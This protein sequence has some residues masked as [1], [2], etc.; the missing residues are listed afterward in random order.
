MDLLVVCPY[1]AGSASPVK[2]T[3]RIPDI[4]YKLDSNGTSKRLTDGTHG[5]DTF[6]FSKVMRIVSPH[7]GNDPTVVWDFGPLFKSMGSISTSKQLNHD[8]LI[9]IEPVSGG[10]VKHELSLKFDNLVDHSRCQQGIRH[11]R[12]PS[13]SFGVVLFPSTDRCIGRGLC[14]TSPQCP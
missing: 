2:Q 8:A 10:F 11:I 9:S 3:G 7:I 12:P 6:P 4:R 5:A 1:P 13:S 14:E